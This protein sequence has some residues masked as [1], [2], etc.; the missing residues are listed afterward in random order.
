M[1]TSIWV[2]HL[3]FYSSGLEYVKNYLDDGYNWQLERAKF[4]SIE[5]KLLQKT[6]K[7][8]YI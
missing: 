3:R 1:I 4:T 7:L 2:R 8:I 6:Y 5:Y